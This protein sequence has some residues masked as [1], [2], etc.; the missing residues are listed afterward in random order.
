MCPRG[1]P[2]GLSPWKGEDG[3]PLDCACGP[4]ARFKPKNFKNLSGAT[5]RVQVPPSAPFAQVR[6][7]DQ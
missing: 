3:P 6:K 1:E 2:D 5:R 4:L 7:L